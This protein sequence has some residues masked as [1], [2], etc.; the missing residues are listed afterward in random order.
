ASTS[1]TIRPAVPIRWSG[2]GPKAPRTPDQRFLSPN[3]PLRQLRGAFW[4]PGVLARV[5]APQGQQPV[6]R[7]EE[8]DRP[9][10]ADGEGGLDPEEG[11]E[12]LQGPAAMAE[13]S[14]PLHV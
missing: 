1:P 2:S 12:K 14:L 13:Q 8:G 6:H 3:A 5:A 11:G 10:D 7:E 9:G 4:H